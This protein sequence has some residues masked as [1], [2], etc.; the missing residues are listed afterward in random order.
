MGL[1]L[2]GFEGFAKTA[3]DLSCEDYQRLDLVEYG[4]K[5]Q[6]LKHADDSIF[7]FSR[8]YDLFGGIGEIHELDRLVIEH[9]RPPSV[10]AYFLVKPAALLDLHA[11][12][13]K[14]FGGHDIAAD[15][16]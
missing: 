6:F 11:H 4:L 13:L 12:G 9:G 7:L 8:S 3:L 16:R 1:R 15:L 2:S 14:I 10:R 5:I